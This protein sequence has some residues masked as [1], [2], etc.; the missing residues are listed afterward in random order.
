MQVASSSLDDFKSPRKKKE[1]KTKLTLSA[2]I[3]A[4]ILVLSSFTRQ[5]YTLLMLYPQF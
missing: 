2:A 1:K 3:A 4:L 5:S